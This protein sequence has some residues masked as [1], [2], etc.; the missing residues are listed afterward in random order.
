[1]LNLIIANI[2]GVKSFCSDLL[3]AI[4]K[5]NLIT[6]FNKKK[7]DYRQLLSFKNF[8]HKEQCEYLKNEKECKRNAIKQYFF[9]EN[10]R[11]GRFILDV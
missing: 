7:H 6:A 8:I 5:T 9:R 1:M 10:S 4:C 2:V 11:S 3:E